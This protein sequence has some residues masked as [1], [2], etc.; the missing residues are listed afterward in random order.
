MSAP[1]VRSAEAERPPRVLRLDPPDGARGVFRDA[2]VVA[3]LSRPV[4]VP[5][6]GAAAFTV[7]DRDGPVPGQ[8]LASPDGRVLVWRPERLLS[9]GVEHLVRVAG[10]R[11]TG[12]RELVAHESAFVPCDVSASD[13]SP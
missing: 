8:V 7:C 13:L 3:V 4:E 11:D 1:R 6:V 5:F 10:L 9:A 12:G 2:S